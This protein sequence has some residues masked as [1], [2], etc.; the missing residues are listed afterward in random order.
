MT[1]EDTVI[2][3]EE[4]VLDLYQI[5]NEEFFK[6]K[7]LK[8]ARDFLK[9]NELL[10]LTVQSLTT[11][12]GTMFF[13][14]ATWV[15]LTRSLS[16]RKFVPSVS[17]DEETLDT[18]VA[19]LLNGLGIETRI[20]RSKSALTMFPGKYSGFVGRM[21]HAMRIPNA[22]GESTKDNMIPK[23]EYRDSS[24]PHYWWD[25]INASPANENEQQQQKLLLRKLCYVL[26]ED[27][28]MIKPDSIYLRLNAFR[29][30]HDG[31][32]FAEDVIDFL[33]RIYK[34]KSGGTGKGALGIFSFD[35]I[36]IDT[37]DSWGRVI[38]DVRISLYQNHIYRLV[39]DGTLKTEVK[40]PAF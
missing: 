3:T 27:R 12:K 39:R 1:L 2:A 26:L 40:Y 14:L 21:Y 36:K 4:Q 7:K 35:Q 24:L 11:P 9:E 20:Q 34:R 17:N 30:E 31:K 15:Y 10:P 13:E 19:P 38:F 25:I 6:R 37:I 5:S 33:N 16:Q 28:L 8:E 32:A 23:S 29:D 22:G 18:K